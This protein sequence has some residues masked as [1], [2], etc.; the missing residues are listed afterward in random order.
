MLSWFA[1][2]GSGL[3]T[4]TDPA[5][6]LAALG[7]V[8][9]GAI[10]GFIPGLGP[11]VAISLAIPISYKLGPLVAIGMM[12]G[13]YKGGTYG[14][15]ISAILINT[16][17]TPAS[18]ATVLDGYPLAKQGKSGK[19]LDTALFSS[20]FG[21]AF[22][23]L[24]L[25]IVAQPLAM[26]AL[27][28][29]A[30]ELC[31]LMLFALTI[32]GGLSGGSLTKGLIS[33]CIGLMLCT[34][35]VDPMSGSPRFDFGFL[36]LQDGLNIIPLVIG[37]FAVAEVL[38]QLKYAGSSYS[39][40]L[41]PPPSTPDDNRLT[42]KEFKYL[43]PVFLQSS[44][45]GTGVGA[46]PGTGSTTAA[47]LSYGAA[48]KRSK[49]PELFGKGSI[50]GLAASETGNNAVCGGAL[51]PMLT[52]GVPGDVVT[53]VLMSALLVHG[54]QV[55]P[56]IFEEH[57]A[58]MFGIFG[59]L[60]ISVIMLFFVGKLLIKL[61][62]KIADLPQAYLMPCVMVLCI[63]GTFATELKVGDMWF[64]MLVGLIGFGISKLNFP[65][66]PMIIAFILMPKLEFNLRQALLL[67]DNDLTVFVTKPISLFFLL[68]TAFSCIQIARLNKK[69][70]QKAQEATLEEQVTG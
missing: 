49:T 30:A 70:A 55:G 35:G 56:L 22:S 13:F 65:P 28:F 31:S 52:L 12:L 5:I 57:R 26:M 29:G 42:L 18:A 17:G 37:L 43:L 15:S 3:L 1:D 39:R 14:G 68:L 61:C 47:Y 63:L 64:L 62:R 6:F 36:Y 58:F 45:I 41:L 40:S 27:K 38:N 44:L 24:T 8:F 48:Q 11:T 16:P 21:D 60:L 50:E 69:K 4:L 23:V 33:T 32:I 66:A 7:G 25:I 10:I 54:I 19:A 2:L 34:I 20:C 67:S 53:A 59:M 46:L 9:F 51:I